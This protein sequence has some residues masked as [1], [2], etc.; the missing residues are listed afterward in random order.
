MKLVHKTIIECL[1]ERVGADGEK[2]AVETGG[3]SCTYRQLDLFSD[4]LAAQMKRNGIGTGVH[5]G[6]WS[7]NSPEWVVT[8]F[9]L[10]KTGAVP[11]LLNTCFQDD[12]ITQVLNYANV[13]VLYY[14]EGYK[15]TSYRDMIE[16]IREKTPNIRRFVSMDRVK[17][18]MNSAGSRYADATHGQKAF[19]ELQEA[20]KKIR[21][22]DTACMIF[23]SGT[24][25]VPKGVLLSHYSLVNNAAAV[26]EA[27]QWSGRDK[28]CITV[29]MFHCFGLTVGILACV[30]C[31]AGM[32]LISC[33][34]T[35]AV[36]DAIENQRCTI[37]NGVPSMFLALIRSSNG[38]GRT[39]PFLNSGIIAGSPIMPE[40]Y[41]EI[42][43]R[44]PSLHLQPSYGQTETSPCV[45]IADWNDPPEKKSASAGK[46]IDFV[47]VRICSVSDGTVEKLD[48]D[49]EIQVKGYNVMEG[50][51]HLPQANREAFTAD[52]WL[53]TGDIGHFDS[54]GEL[55]V[56]GRLKEMI[57]RGGENISPREI[58][59]A[60]RALDWVEQVKV[61][62]VPDKV[63]QEAI[64]ACIIP[65]Q[66]CQVDRNGLF[67][68]LDKK[69]SQYKM[70]SY[71]FE[72][73]SFPFN[74]SG[75]I[76]LEKIRKQAAVLAEQAAKEKKEEAQIWQTRIL[77]SNMS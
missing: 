48:K 60:I 18:G 33:F 63:M 65:K 51:Y 38:R 73:K 26:S 43:E 53:K 76:Q 39:A 56:T 55:H 13:E 67:R 70:P 41:K 19:A 3:W 52:G 44:F 35:G 32:Y 45:T 1:T 72:F 9:A 4:L 77:R 34:R 27:M 30:I 15:A 2:T 50:Y 25:L 59:R 29:P 17:D 57:I 37:L 49:G 21:P 12:E 71:V 7:V 31:G 61:V 36:W 40:D 10:V 64:A 46:P 66:G 16:R 22:Q 6:I 75:K 47:S 68:Y 62:G 42:C 20:K 8:F 24:T 23:T 74:A 58:E 14:G 69:L 5:V 54:D 11:V 28:M